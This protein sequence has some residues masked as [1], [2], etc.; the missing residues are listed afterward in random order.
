MRES[1]RR[2]WSDPEWL[3]A[4][5]K[6]VKNAER[7]GALPKVRLAHDPDTGR[8]LKRTPSEGVADDK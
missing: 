6:A 8:F 3:A 5:P 4:H 2:R 1:A 7:F